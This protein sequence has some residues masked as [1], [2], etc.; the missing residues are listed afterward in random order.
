MSRW[1]QLEHGPVSVGIMQHS[2]RKSP[3][4]VVR[5][6][7]VIHTVAYCRDEAE[8]DRLWEALIELTGANREIPR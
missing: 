8:A 2:T 1:G 4:V 5:R 6:G 7:S 3:A